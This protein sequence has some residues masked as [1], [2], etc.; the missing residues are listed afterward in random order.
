MLEA[1]AEAGYRD[2]EELII[3][4]F[5]MHSRSC[6]LES[7]TISGAG[8][9][10]LQEIDRLNPNLI[11]I[12]D[13]NAIEHVMLPLAKSRYPIF[14]AG[15]NIAPET[16]N[17]IK[18]FMIN[19]LQPGFNITGVTEE[20]EH[21]HSFNLIKEL[22]PQAKTMAIVSS[23]STPFLKRMNDTFRA[24][25][26][27]HQTELPFQIKNFIEVKYLAE[28]KKTMLELAENPA[29]DLIYPYVPISLIR[30]DGKGAGLDETLGWTFNH[31][32]KPEMTWLVDFVKMGY[33]ATIGIDLETCGHQLAGK[34]G[35]AF[36]GL[37]P[38]E[39]PIERPQ[40]YAIA[41]NQARARQLDIEFPLELLDSAK[42]VFQDMAVCKPK[43]KD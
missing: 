37:F 22:C 18:P 7:S 10:V 28:Y 12:F 13:D 4:R 2:G 38:A 30:A 8:R 34:I 32:K 33:L 14:F 42:F 5:H 19:R 25:L 21:Q 27:Q 20:T 41:L 6:N 40:K 9:E 17:A 23:S 35:Q 36:Q 29:I 39:I 1:L 16:Y 24:W 11:V 43:N 31:I 15:M 3:S 26:D